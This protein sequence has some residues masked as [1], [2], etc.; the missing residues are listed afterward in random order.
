MLSGRAKLG[1]VEIA[2]DV[3]GTSGR[4]LVLIMGI[5][6]QRVFWDDQMCEQLVEAGFR[7]ARFDHRDIG[8]SS[9]LDAPV[10]HPGRMLA[11]RMLGVTAKPPYTLSDMASDV[12]QLIRTIGFGKSHIVGASMGGMIGQHLALEHPELVRSLTSIMSTPGGRRY[13]PRP[14]ALKALFMPPP[15]TAEEAGISVDNLFQTIGGHAFPHDSDR[16]RAIGALSHER[17]AN[18]RGFLRHFAAIMGTADRRA[19]LRT[20]QVPTLVIHGS[21]DPLIPMSAGKALARM[22]PDAT[23]LPISGMGHGLPSAVWPVVVRAIARHAERADARA[24]V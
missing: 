19:K 2:Y 1:E 20:S 3:F 16:L 17:G 15:K 22:M 14:F 7:V 8:E 11:L 13:L 24:T 23:W 18:P 10:P 6:A 12:A 9:R 21:S 4:P 5:G